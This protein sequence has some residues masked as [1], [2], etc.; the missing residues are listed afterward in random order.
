MHMMKNKKKNV[1]HQ[2]DNAVKVGQEVIDGDHSESDNI[3]NKN[4]ELKVQNADSKEKS[5]DI[6]TLKWVQENTKQCPGCKNP[7]EKND[8]CFMMTCS[9]CRFQFCWLCLSAWSTHSNHFQCAKFPQGQLTNKPIFIDDT[10]KTNQPVDM[11]EQ[12]MNYIE[13]YT[14]YKT[15]PEYEKNLRD[16]IETVIIPH[17]LARNS[18]F[19]IDL[20]RTSIELLFQLRNHVR[21]MYVALAYEKDLNHQ[22]LICS[23]QSTFM[24]M[25]E[26]LAQLL[27]KDLVEEYITKNTEWHK[28]L[29]NLVKLTN[30]VIEKYFLDLLGS[31]T[32]EDQKDLGTFLSKMDV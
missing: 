21:N 10:Q 12:I 3:K 8:G 22:F 26:K 27:E 31:S 7:I 5:E 13:R 1:E 16:K 30:Q 28:P 29:K 23:N 6:R 14:A 18:M 9:K 25:A 2:Q 32:V 17:I 19:N 20:L 4:I 15:R 24:M 11:D